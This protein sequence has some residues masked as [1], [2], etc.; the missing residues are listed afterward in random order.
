MDEIASTTKD[1]PA[2]SREPQPPM[3]TPVEAIDLSEAPTVRTKLRIYTILLSLFVCHPPHRTFGECQ[4]RKALLTSSCFGASSIWHP[5]H[6]LL[7]VS[8]DACQV[9]ED[10]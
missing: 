4:P 5:H 1:F 8:A 6:L 9:M 2:D 10:A 3:T 7:L